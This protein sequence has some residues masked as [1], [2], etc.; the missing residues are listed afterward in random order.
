MCH[1]HCYARKD[2]PKAAHQSHHTVSVPMVGR[3][4]NAGMRW[5]QAS[6]VFVITIQAAAAAVTKKKRRRAMNREGNIAIRIACHIPRN[7]MQT[8]NDFHGNS[9][10]NEHGM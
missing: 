2:E 6:F 3:A 9:G 5:K 7:I 10:F 8:R 4:C 1:S